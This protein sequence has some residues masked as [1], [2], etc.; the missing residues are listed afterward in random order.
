[1]IR[2]QGHGVVYGEVWF[3]E[4]P[5]ADS[6]VDILV[7]QRRREPISNAHTALMYSLMTD[8][9]AAPE[10]IAAGLHQT[11]RYQIH[12]AEAKDRLQHEMATDSADKLDEFAAFFAEFAK[13]KS[14][15]EA[16][17]HWLTRVAAERQLVLSNASRDGERLVWHAYLRSAPYVIL[18]YSASL[19]RGK[20]NYDRA[21]LGRA[22][23]WLHWKEMMD[24]KEG[25]VH[26]YDWGGMF[27]DESTAERAGI[28]RFKRMFGGVPVRSYQCTVPATLRGQVWLPLRDAWRRWKQV[29]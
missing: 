14:L 21:L 11:C 8:L 27:D 29:R 19:F 28:N 20:D 10:S 13:Q 18:V 22:N 15:R 12:R 16:D 5:P 23:R 26:Y 9:S 7:Y 3:D 17:R 24:F 4:E 25:G 1:M 2:I 6:S